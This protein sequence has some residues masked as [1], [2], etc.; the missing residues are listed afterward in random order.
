L[1]LNGSTITTASGSVL[2]FGLR[3][4]VLPA[5]INPVAQTIN[6]GSSIS[7]SGAV[8]A[9]GEVGSVYTLSAPGYSGDTTVVSATLKLGAVNPNNEVST[10]SVAS[11][12]RIDIAFSGNDT[13]GTLIL[14]GTTMPPGTY[15]NTTHP[16]FF[17]ATGSG[18]IVV[19]ASSGYSAWQTANGAAGQTVDLDHDNDGVDNGIEYFMGGSTNTS[20]FTVTPVL[21]TSNQITWTMGDSYIGTYGTDYVIQTSNEL[22]TWEPVAEANVTLDN[23]APGKSVSYTL[24]GAGKR[25]VR[26]LVKPN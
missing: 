6:V 20:G 15:N 19:A 8:S 24:T 3:P 12:A 7:G 21:N 10:V 26:L 14:G 13:V 22:T 1:E 23:V 11:G 2:S 16:T 17:S 25:F 5:N 9:Q 18:N 4:A